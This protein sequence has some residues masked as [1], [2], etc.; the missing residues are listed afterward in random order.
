VVEQ[1][2]PILETIFVIETPAYPELELDIPITI[3]TS[4]GFYEDVSDLNGIAIPS[5]YYDHL[6]KRISGTE[7]GANSPTEQTV[8]VGAK[9][10]LQ[11]IRD[12]ME[13]T[14][15]KEYSYLKQMIANLPETITTPEEYL[16]LSNIYVSVNEKL[17]FRLNQ[18]GRNDYG[19]LPP[20]IIQECISRFDE[21]VGAECASPSDVLIEHSIVDFSKEEE[22]EKLRE[23]LSPFFDENAPK[24]RFS[25][26]TDLVTPV[27]VWEMKCT[28]AITMEHQLQVVIYAWLW[29]ILY[30]DT[31]REFRI[32]NIRSGEIQRLNTTLDELTLIVVSLLRGKYTKLPEKSDDVF[33]HECREA[34]VARNPCT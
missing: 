3:H 6:Y 24:F 26:R 20:L 8:S 16:Y 29:N 14:R 1:V 30:A 25:A 7:E 11:L 23:V 12:F 17:Y 31:P 4:L 28:T 18:I 5:I 32:L 15:D 27:N 13:V 33:M 10:L 21:T 22:N 9:I 19:W 34:I 2:T